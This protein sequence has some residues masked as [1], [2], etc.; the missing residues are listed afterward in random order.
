MSPLWDDVN[1]R[2]R[3]LGTRL[4][5]RGQLESLA[6]A[7]DAAALWAAF[8][9]LG[10]PVAGEREAATSPELE[11]AVR[12]WAAAAL[13]TPALW[14]VAGSAFAFCAGRAFIG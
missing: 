10:L 7:A 12:R 13:R 11:L 9:R 3:G 6:R 4:F 8:R 2:A 5:T 1:A 14:I